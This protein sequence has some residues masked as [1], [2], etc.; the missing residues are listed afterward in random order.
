MADLLN[1]ASLL[2]ATYTAPDVSSILAGELGP[3]NCNKGTTV[4][5]NCNDGNSPTATC[6]SGVYP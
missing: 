4:T 3:S 6:T 1:L 2:P 5:S